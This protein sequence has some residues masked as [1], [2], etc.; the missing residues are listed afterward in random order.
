MAKLAVIIPAAGS[1]SRMG[2]RLP[3]PFLE[4]CGKS[5]LGHTITSF[6]D[7]EGLAQVIIATSKEWFAEV[8][9]TLQSFE[10][11]GVAFNLVEG[12]A[13]RQFSIHN[14]LGSLQP[15]IELV[16]VHD[17]V[18]PFISVE[19]INKCCS[20]A[21]ELGGAIIAVP[22]KDTIK[23]VNEAGE[24]QNTPERKKLWQAQTPQVF[25]KELL[26]EAYS[27]AIEENFVGTDDSSLVERTGGSVGVVEGDRENLKI[28]Y[29]IDLKI[30]ELILNERS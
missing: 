18:R 24:I 14:A 2:S 29:P 22:A 6:L 4:L 21:M 27:K 1:G 15:D 9:K 11:E 3:K 12:G 19:L 23:Q 13:E 10:V 5:I 17:A 16:A 30:A 28:T 20:K 7:A 25:R 26:V 8:E